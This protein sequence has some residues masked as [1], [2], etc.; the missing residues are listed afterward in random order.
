M[1]DFPYILVYKRVAFICFVILTFNII[2]TRDL[3]FFNFMFLIYHATVFFNFFINA[4]FTGK[5]KKK[6]DCLC[7]LPFH[8]G[9][10]ICS[11]GAFLLDNFVPIGIVVL[12]TTCLVVTLGRIW[13][14]EDPL[15]MHILFDNFIFQPFLYHKR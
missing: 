5:C 8:T 15:R 1:V 12:F 4:T 7:D 14:L 10:G 13:N 3:I 11:I 6:M 2:W 9:K